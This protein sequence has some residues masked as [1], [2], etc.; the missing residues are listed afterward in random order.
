MVSMVSYIES[1]KI[2]LWSLSKK[3]INDLHGFRMNRDR[4][5]NQGLVVMALD[6]LDKVVLTDEADFVTYNNIA[7]AD[8]ISINTMI[9]KVLSLNNKPTF[10]LDKT[11]AS[12]ID[13]TPACVSYGYTV[14]DADGNGYNE[15]VIGTQTWLVQNLRVTKLS[16]GDPIPNVT[17]NTAWSELIT[18]AY[19]DYNNTPSNSVIYGRL[20]NQYAIDEGIAIPTG[21]HI[22]TQSEYFTMISY[23][24]GGLLAGGKLKEAGLSHWLTP[25]T[26][27][28][29]SSGFTSLPGG[30][31]GISGQFLSL[32][33][34]GYYWVSDTGKNFYTEC[35][36]AEILNQS[37]IQKSYGMGIRLIKD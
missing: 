30:F 18:S 23:L 28:T 32:T 20:Y 2:G 21:W 31:R 36:S 9:N 6:L 29:N 10:Y 37:G 19:C 34:K 3:R 5:V 33:E 12:S 15:I 24:D 1:V 16:N 8:L 27:A 17:D 11:N 25:N 35:N 26:G 13:C 7:H 4:D 22:P 14:V